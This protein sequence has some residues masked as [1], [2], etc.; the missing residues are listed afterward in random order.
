MR[1][2]MKLLREA[3]NE[4][5]DAER[6]LDYRWGMLN[7][8]AKRMPDDDLGMY[9]LERRSAVV[10]KATRDMVKIMDDLLAEATKGDE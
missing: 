9:A 5:A 6:C 7:N 4:G 1:T 2:M 10:A 3:I 8:G